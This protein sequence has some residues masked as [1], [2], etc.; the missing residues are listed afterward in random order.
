MKYLN[1]KGKRAGDF[2]F[3]I[4]EVLLAAILLAAALSV[5]LAITSRS[6]FAHVNK[7]G[8]ELAI[9]LAD[10]TLERIK[11]SLDKLPKDKAR[12][13]GQ[14]AENYPGYSWQANLEPG[15][16][17]IIKVNVTVFW[18]FNNIENSY[19]LST[20]FYEDGLK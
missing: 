6:S 9:L 15:K 18:D 1:N 4:I 7:T 2:G 19:S 11:S 3:T 12:M 13:S 8:N 16:N 17:G 14:F 10:E 20:W 5:L